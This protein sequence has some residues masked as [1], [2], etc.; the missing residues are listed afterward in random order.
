MKA[1]PVVSLVVTVFLTCPNR[2][3]QMPDAHEL[4]LTR[5]LQTKTLD[6]NGKFRTFLPRLSHP[7]LTTKSLLLELL[8]R[9]RPRESTPKK[10]RPTNV[11]VTKP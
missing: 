7:H 8:Y 2:S 4:C 9:P 1:L 3:K 5:L 6:V 11:G 10:K